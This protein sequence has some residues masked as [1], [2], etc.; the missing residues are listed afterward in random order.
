[1]TIRNGTLRSPNN[2]TIAVVG[3]IGNFF[4]DVSKE[5]LEERIF[6]L[7]EIIRNWEDHLAI[8]Q[9]LVNSKFLY[10]KVEHAI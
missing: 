7:S 3:L 8:Y 2:R 10:Q 9:D 1:L 6:T 4:F 5:I